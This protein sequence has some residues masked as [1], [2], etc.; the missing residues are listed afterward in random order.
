MTTRLHAL[1]ASLLATVAV[2]G[3]AGEAPLA[4]TI[5]G[6]DFIEQGLPASAFADGW[7]VTFSRFLVVVTE[8][9][10]AD[11]D[12]SEA[13][14]LDGARVVDLVAPGPFT[15]VE[16]PAVAAR[17]FDDVEIVIAPAADATAGNA[18]ADDVARMVDGGLSVH[19][20]ARAARGAEVATFAWSFAAATRYGDCQTV[21]DGSGQVVRADVDNEAQIT[22]HGDHLFYDDLAGD[23][24]VL[25]FDDVAAADGADGTAPD[26]DVGQ[27]ELDAVDLTTL[28]ADRYGNAGSAET[29]GD[30][31]EALSRT[32]IHW[33]G[34]GEC[35]ISSP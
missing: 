7:S 9:R 35:S 26:G 34:E 17:R 22:V 5:W 31:V 1:C 32:L 6:E 8:A 4:L 19:V 23:D 28:P 33:N 13:L 30:F 18:T 12:G 25:R 2:T 10:I 3:C 24:A 14:A 29:L 27:T 11:A 20:E 15:L 21:G 16:A